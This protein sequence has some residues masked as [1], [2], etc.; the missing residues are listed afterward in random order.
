MA[1]NRNT[2]SAQASKPQPERISAAD[3]RKALEEP[4]RGNRGAHGHYG[5]DGEW[6]HSDVEEILIARLRQFERAGK[7]KNLKREVRFDIHA[8][9]GKY[10][11]FAKIDAGFWD[12][13]QERQRYQDAKSDRVRDTRESDLKF[14][15]IEAEYGITIE[16]V[17][18][19]TPRKRRIAPWK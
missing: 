1:Y 4:K 16:K 3:Y 13:E 2:P 11:C 8:K 7:I 10:V 15:L 5:A 12:V 19:K 6:Y 17:R 9:G 14:K 18:L